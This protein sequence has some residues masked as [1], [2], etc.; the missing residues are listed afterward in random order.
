M[1]VVTFN[2]NFFLEAAGS[3][4]GADCGKAQG[5]GAAATGGPE[6]SIPLSCLEAL[7]SK[8]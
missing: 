5:G 7:K 6:P 8:Q 4:G 2:C 3:S 1:E